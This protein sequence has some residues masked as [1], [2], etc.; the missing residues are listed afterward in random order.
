MEVESRLLLYSVAFG[1]A[2]ELFVMLRRRAW[3]LWFHAFLLGA[4]LL[5]ATA[6]ALT[7][8]ART[9]VLAWP[10]FTAFLLF[11]VVPAMF[12]MGAR[13]LV[14]RRRY[15]WAGRLAWAGSALLG[16]PIATRAESAFYAALAAADRG[17][18]DEAR[19]RLLA[20]HE[21]GLLGSRQGG[22]TI[23]EALPAAAD[24]DWAGVLSAIDEAPS[25]APVVVGLAAR[26]AAESGD[27]RRAVRA[28]R[29]LRSPPVPEPVRDQAWRSVLAAGGRVSALCDD[30]V[31]G[32]LLPP[33]RAGRDLVLARAH[34]AAGD[35]AAAAAAYERATRLVHGTQL[36]EARAGLARTRAGEGRRAALD[37]ETH[38]DLL[39]LEADCRAAGAAR[40][41]TAP[42]R[43]AR[44]VTWLSVVSFLVSVAAFAFIGF[45]GDLLGANGPDLLLAGALSDPLVRDGEW[46][47]LFSAMNL[48]GG[49]V[50]LLMNIGSILLIG[51]PFERR[52]GWAR[53]VLVYVGSGLIGSL[54]SVWINE[55]PIGVGASGAA[56]G[57]TGG[58]LVLLTARSGAFERAFRKRWLSVLWLCVAATAAIGLLEHEH[59]DNAAHG[60][61]LVGGALLTFLFLPPK[62]GAGERTITP[63]LVR[64]CA[65]LLL[66]LFA[67]GQ[68]AAWVA[69][70]RGV[71]ARPF[72]AQGVR[73]SVP[74]VL[75]ARPHELGGVV[76]ERDPWSVRVYAGSEPAAMPSVL[77]LL[78]KG[79][80]VRAAFLAAHPDPLVGDAPVVVRIAGTGAEGD[81]GSE[82]VRIQRVRNGAAFALVMLPYF[83][84]EPTGLEWIVEHMRRS[85]EPVR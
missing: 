81:V 32:P 19:R 7:S 66:V 4:V 46:W 26:A 40:A 16:F 34:E 50:H 62:R 79:D 38:A 73:G 21:R 76:A 3:A 18:T 55:T 56:M 52:M 74:R 54:A 68:V 49:W 22:R 6:F 2:L 51:F 72:E 82:A 60:A 10:L 48:H 13:R 42:K 67:W 59:V 11:S 78:P 8:S 37:P 1:V 65:V 70:V 27:M 44:A 25:R 20:L 31:A 83:E 45:D 29:S 69:A 63:A 12:L 43:P 17:D 35:D 53:T 58:L 80:P 5:P 9:V 39:A 61:G 57:L 30:A 36:R 14:G 41:A 75:H 77:R 64:L 85:L 71:S 47:R 28:A 15:A 84:G 24:H 33:P 23:A